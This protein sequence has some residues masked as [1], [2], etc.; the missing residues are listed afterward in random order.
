MIMSQ[1]TP[2]VGILSMTCHTAGHE[3]V[4]T[5]KKSTSNLL[6]STAVYDAGSLTALFTPGA[7]RN[8]TPAL[9][10]GNAWG[11]R[12]AQLVLSANQP[13]LALQVVKRAPPIALYG[14]KT[15]HHHEALQG[16]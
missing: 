11:L 16:G 7:D 12:Q 15:E 6:L 4:F 14:G 10:P 5:Q 9:D 3:R 1:E 8:G 13:P 2:W